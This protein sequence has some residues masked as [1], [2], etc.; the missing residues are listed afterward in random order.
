MNQLKPIKSNFNGLDNLTGGFFP[1]EVTVVGARPTIG[2][3]AFIASLIKNIIR[4]PGNNCLFFSIEMCAETFCKRLAASMLRMPFT[5]IRD[6]I[7]N[8][9]EAAQ[10]KKQ[11]KEIYDLPLHIEDNPNQKIADICK[12][13]KKIV[14]EKHI[15][16]IFIDYLGLIQTSDENAAV[17]E[18]TSLVI[19]K[20][21]ILAREINIPIVITCQ[22]SRSGYPSTPPDLQSLRG[23]GDIEGVADVVLLIDRETSKEICATNLIVAKNHNG[24]LGTV[25]LKF[26]PEIVLFEE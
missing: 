26:I 17:Y 8:D 14:R 11:L 22:V 20:L 16:I 23:T 19:K 18:Q 4:E 12:Q 25:E 2:K 5:K 15:K 7:L 1:G 10:L 21:K 6:S 9:E 24:K 13:A 3:T